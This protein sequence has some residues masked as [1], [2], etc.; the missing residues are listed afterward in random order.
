M[1]GGQW[2]CGPGEWRGVRHRVMAGKAEGALRPGRGAAGGVTGSPEGQRGHGGPDIT[3]R[4]G[5]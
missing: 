3:G 1:G 2:C 4:G 5:G